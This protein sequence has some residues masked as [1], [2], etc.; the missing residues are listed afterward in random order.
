MPLVPKYLN[1]DEQVEFV[2]E[3]F[4]SD[5]DILYDFFE[6]G[7][8]LG[9]FARSALIGQA[10]AWLPRDLIETEL[11]KGE[12]KRLSLEHGE[13]YRL[14]VYLQL[15]EA[16]LREIHNRPATQAMVKLLARYFTPSR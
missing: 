3:I 2:D 11:A 16:S 7:E 5:L 4:Q 15:N 1:E 6:W 13:V 10:Y 12:L 14:A 9:S 8:K